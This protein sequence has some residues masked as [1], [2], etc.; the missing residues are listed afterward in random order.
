MNQIERIRGDLVARFPDLS[1]TIDAPDSDKGTWFMDVRRG[2]EYLVGVEWRPGRN[3]A[4]STPKPDS[5]GSG[6]DE[7]YANV[8]DAF[9]RVAHL[10]ET[11]GETS[12]PAS[13]RIAELRQIRGMSQAELAERA[14]LKQGN[15]SRFEKQGDAMV[16][17]LAKIVAGLG[18][19]L[20]IQARFPD[21]VALD[22]RV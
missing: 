10:I 13:V 2:D 12:P 11:G 9:D 8:R 14:G 15:V 20:A 6:A 18:G 4:V 1:V 5:Y 3:F 21:G 7:V 17:T 22:L 19:S 16:S